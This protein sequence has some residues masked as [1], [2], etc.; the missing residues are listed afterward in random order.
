MPV[1]WHV[2]GHIEKLGKKFGK[3]KE[4][5]YSMLL[6]QYNVVLTNNWKL[7]MKLGSHMWTCPQWQMTGLPC[8]HALVIVAKANI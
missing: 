6:G 4:E 3:H 7:V 8:C 2:S 5:C 1:P